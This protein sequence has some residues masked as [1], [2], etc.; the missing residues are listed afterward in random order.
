MWAEMCSFAL[1]SC[2]QL[3]GA[4]GFRRGPGGGAGCWEVREGQDEMCLETQSYLSTSLVVIIDRVKGGLFASTDF[5]LSS[6][7]PENP[8]VAMSPEVSSI[9]L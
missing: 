9:Y 1:E 8:R 5:R 3:E 4:T 6:Q 7:K 2:N